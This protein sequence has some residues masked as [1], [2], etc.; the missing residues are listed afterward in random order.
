MAR[1]LITITIQYNPD[2]NQRWEWLPTLGTSQELRLPRPFT[3]SC[4]TRHARAGCTA[5]SAKLRP[6]ASLM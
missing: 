6:F 3:R 4:G 5:D 1:P 2:A